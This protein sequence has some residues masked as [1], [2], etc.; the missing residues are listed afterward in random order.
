MDLSIIAGD[1]GMHLQGLKNT[2]MLVSLSLTTGLL[3]AVPLSILM[4]RGHAAIRLPV[5]AFV[6]F[7]RGTP[8]LAQMLLVYCG[9][10]QTDVLKGTFLWPMFKEAYFCALFT[11][12][13]NTCAYTT[14]I[15]RGAVLATAP[16]E[17]EAARAAGLSNMRLLRQVIL[18]SACR[19]LSTYSKEIVFMLHGCVLTSAITI[20]TLT[21]A[22]RIVNSLRYNPYQAFF[23]AAA[24]YL[25]II[26][27]VILVVKMVK[28]R[29]LERPMADEDGVAELEAT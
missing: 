1:Y 22:A 23:S 15:L 16:G 13:L 18:P 24:M 7:F 17:L 8:L 20:F 9:L 3:L 21:G 10:G 14:E 26:L 25:T 5:R 12:C 11:F 2:L 4:T 28:K 19:R 6:W 27:S 29:W